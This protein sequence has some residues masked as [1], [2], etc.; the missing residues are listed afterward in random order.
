MYERLLEPGAIG[1]MTLKNRLIVPAMTTRF[2][3]ED[4][5]ATE[6][7]IAY[8]EA[9]ARGGWA[10]L[11]TENFVIDRGVGVKRELP[12]IWND[13]QRDSYRPFTRR[14]HE[15]G[16]KVAA[17]LYH[18]GRNT[19]SG[20]TGIHNVA[21]SPICD[22]S[23]REVPHELTEAE[24]KEIVDKFGSAAARAKVAG[25]DAVELHGAHGYLIAQFL[26]PFSNKRGDRYGGTLYNRAR[27]A[28]EIVT[29]VRRR[30][31]EDYPIL[32]RISATEFIPEGINIEHTKAI[33]RI[34][35][36][37]GV[38]AFNVSQSG[39]ATFYN[40]V[41]SYYVPN[42]A[43]LNLAAEVKKVVHVPAIAVGRIN[44]PE[45][46]EEALLSGKADLIAMGRASVADSELPNKLAAGLTEEIQTCIG[47]C[48]GCLGNTIRKKPLGCLVNP[49]AGKETLYRP[50]EKAAAVRKVV[51]AG[52]GVSGC[53]AAITAARRGHSVILLEKSGQLGG[54]WNLAA[55]PPFKSEFSSLIAWQKVMLGKL[56]VDVRLSTAATRELLEEIRPDVVL[57]AAGSLPIQLNIPGLE[58]IR[59]AFAQ[60]VLAGKVEAG[61]HPVIV[62]GG[63]VG[64]E[65]AEYV[66]AGHGNPEIVELQ[67]AIAKDCEPGPKYFLLKN[68][69]D[70][71]VPIHTS[72]R[73]L[74]VEGDSVVYLKDDAEHVIRE[75]DQVILAVGVR[76]N[77][78]LETELE[79]SGIS[80]IPVGDANTAKNGLSNI[81]EAMETAMKI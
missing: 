25:F 62:G 8:H 46:A 39:P 32:F 81:Q 6:Q 77:R 74:R 73:I 66:A 64:A 51:V 4:G 52:G 12:G 47:C 45:L 33:C 79:G 13:E 67:E 30:V 22:P 72:A 20:I 17:Q 5:K 50:G 44:S 15:A 38:D 16:G 29:E 48:Q 9:R 53:T 10:M 59:W 56:G 80:V 60:D 37:A 58:G 69:R 61:A 68:L 24:I 49:Y 14:I 35:E 36:K 65:T 28:Q 42:G 31:G 2:V 26:S 40:T 76:P 19:H 3:G 11:I 21:P 57:D 1:R 43:F 34:L 78:T 55:M 75:V 23:N 71:G 41:P 27:F 18:A 54:Q 63:L 70:H 7:F